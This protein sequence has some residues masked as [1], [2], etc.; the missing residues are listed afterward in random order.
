MTSERVLLSTCNRTELYIAHQADDQLKAKLIQW[1]AESRQILPEELKSYLYIYYDDEA[2]KHIL[3]VVSGLDSMVLGEPQILGQVKSSHSVALKNKTTGAVL[4]RLMQYSFTTAKKIRTQT[5]IGANPVSV[6]YAAVSLAKQ[7]FANLNQQTALLVGA[8]ETIELVGRHLQSNGI[9]RIIVANR[10]VENAQY[11]ADEFSGEAI[12]LK[13]IAN[14]L[15]EA[16]IVISSTAAPI[17]VIGKGSVERALKKRKHQP[18]FMVDIA[19][20]RDIEPEVSTLDDVYLYTVDDLQTVIEENKQS[21]QTAANQAEQ[22][23][24]QE[25]SAYM[26][27]LRAQGQLDLIREYRANSAE[28]KDE[29]LKKALKLLR[30]GKSPE[31]TLEFLA[32][33]LTNKLSHT[34]TAAM[35][36]AAHSGDTKLLE[37]ARSLLNLK[38]NQ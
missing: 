31:D 6:A 38:K 25:V 36:K 14:R 20:P 17:P 28:L 16:D 1:L 29:T 5:A 15:H 22:M 18:M 2:V 21:R 8:G 23:V 3:R 11:L 24:T 30:N 33:T 13:E 10:S 32:H 7:I 26:D 12:P 37:A 4:N 34:P 27:W 9:G 19:V 35:N